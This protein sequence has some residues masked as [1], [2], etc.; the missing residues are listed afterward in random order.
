MTAVP[1]RALGAERAGEVGREAAALPVGVTAGERNRTLVAEVRQGLRRE[2]GA[3]ALRAV[4]EH[5]PRAVGGDALDSRLEVAA[6]HVHGPG[7]ASLLPLVAVADGDEQRS[8]VAV[9]Q[10]AGGARV[11]LVDRGL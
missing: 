4:E 7:D 6:R 8:V 5:R 1:G 2:G 11:D 3:V 10:L 9:Q